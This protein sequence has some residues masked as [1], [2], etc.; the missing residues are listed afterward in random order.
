MS[1]A[2]A[3]SSTLLFHYSVPLPRAPSHALI[4]GKQSIWQHRRACC[5]RN[6]RAGG[7]NGVTAQA[8]EGKT[9]LPVVILP[10]LGN[11]ATDY[12]T[13]TERLAQNGHAAV[14]VAPVRRWQWLLNARGVLTR[15]YWTGEL[16][17]SP[18]LDWYFA[19]VGI[20][21]E[22]ACAAQPDGGERG[23]INMVA[24]SAGGWLARA[25]LA[26]HAPQSLRVASLVT[27]GTPHVAPPPG[28]PDQT[29]GLLRYVAS[30]CDIRVARFA[31]VAGCG[32]RGKAVGT[33]SVREAVAFASYAAVCGDGDV[34]G[35]GITPVCAT[36]VTDA[37]RVLCECDHSMLT[38]PRNWYGSEHA[39]AQWIEHLV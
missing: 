4:E 35:D 30:R 32:T 27:L 7:A 16:Q 12:A 36:K 5:H 26:E 19:A 6:A 10:G 37:R 38:S 25:Y 33:G 1:N 21:I 23:S 31:S 18:T 8:L 29:R 20:A 39:L 13:L 15:A 11:A 2:A 17:P 3:H 22:Q 9:R 24:H 28:S 34:D 14:T